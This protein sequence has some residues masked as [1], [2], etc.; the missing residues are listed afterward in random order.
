MMR[1]TSALL[2]V[3]R[4][5]YECVR[6]VPITVASLLDLS[7]LDD[8]RNHQ[9]ENRKRFHEHDTQNHCALNL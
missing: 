6:F 4:Q 3:V 9:S 7:E 2:F 8:K 5:T 1:H